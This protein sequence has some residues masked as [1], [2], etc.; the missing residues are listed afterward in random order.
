MGY[1]QQVWGM[2]VRD[3]RQDLW[4]LSMIASTRHEAYKLKIVLLEMVDVQVRLVPCGQS[5]RYDA[6]ARLLEG[7]PAQR[8]DEMCARFSQGRK[9]DERIFV[10]RSQG[11]SQKELLRRCQN[12]A[13]KKGA[14]P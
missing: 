8:L 5:L 1:Q 9:K 14:N 3:D 11:L 13:R 6:A 2:F 7:V 10:R 12:L 4:R